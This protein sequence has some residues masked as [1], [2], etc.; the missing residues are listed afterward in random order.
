MSEAEPETDDDE[1]HVG[2]DDVEVEGMSC[3]DDEMN[4][5]ADS[6]DNGQ[7]SDDA[8]T[9]NVLWT[10][11]LGF[12]AS[13]GDVSED[14][15]EDFAVD[16]DVFGDDEIEAF[17]AGEENEMEIVG[18]QEGVS[19][20][21]DDDVTAG[22]ILAEDESECDDD[23]ITRPARHL[24]NVVDSDDDGEVAARAVHPPGTMA[25][26]DE[27]APGDIDNP[28]EFQIKENTVM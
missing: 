14:E 24:R 11:E 16:E 19:D 28:C 1:A 6:D 21:E 7:D 23:E 25:V 27:L 18:V 15:R 20:A 17:D 9:D 8:E 2:Y 13:D 4:Q 10:V 5:A 22:M 3:E 12:A 26:F